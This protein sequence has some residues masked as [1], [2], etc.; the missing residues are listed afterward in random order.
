MAPYL[1]II[2]QEMCS[3]VDADFNSID[4]KKPDW[5]SKYYWT[6]SEQEQFRLWL[7]DYLKDKKVIK[8]LTN[9]SITNLKVREKVANEFVFMYGWTVDY[10]ADE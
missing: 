4:F 9:I 10:S 1:K 8:E 5:Y 2:L 3:R 7:I 6:H